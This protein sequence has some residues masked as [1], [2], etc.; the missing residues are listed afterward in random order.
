MKKTKGE[1]PD[2]SQG[3]S[4]IAEGLTQVAKTLTT[5]DIQSL[6]RLSTRILVSLP[7][8]E[9]KPRAKKTPKERQV[10]EVFSQ[11]EGH[12]LLRSSSSPAEIKRLPR[13]VRRVQPPAPKTRK[14]ILEPEEVW[15]H[16]FYHFENQILVLVERSPEK[17]EITL[18]RGG[19]KLTSTT[20]S[21][22]AAD[23]VALARVL[24]KAKLDLDF[25]RVR[26]THHPGRYGKAEPPTNLAK[27]PEGGRVK[28][29]PWDPRR[30]S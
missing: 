3:L 1:N 6:L 2:L 24:S 14:V 17:A 19:E 28:F 11:I 26:I 23:Q 12:L 13:I 10:A 27:A 30:H 8:E 5:E 22:S 21:G 20:G 25:S 16:T 4:R 18:W 15:T 7:R 9:R 29:A